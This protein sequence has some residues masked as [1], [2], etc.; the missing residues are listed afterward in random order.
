MQVYIVSYDLDSPGPQ[1]YD[2]LIARLKQLGAT[3]ILFSQWMLKFVS[4][5]A[6]LE[7]DLMQYIDPATD[8]FLVMP[9]T[10]DVAWNKLMISDDEF[11]T[12]LNG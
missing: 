7:H 1:N 11:R 5:A 4:N 3:R 9:L 6:S 2:R 8:S 12:W 10:R